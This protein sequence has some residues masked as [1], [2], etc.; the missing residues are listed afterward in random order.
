MTRAGVILGTAGVHESRAG[1]RAGGRQAHRHLGVRLRAVRDADRH[2]APFDGDDAHGHDRRDRRERA[3]LAGAARRERRRRP[4]RCCGVPEEDPQRAA[5]R[6]RRRTARARRRGGRSPDPAGGASKAPCALAASVAGSPHFCCWASPLFL[7]LR[8]APRR[9]PHPNLV[10]LQIVP[11]QNTSF[12]SPISATVGVPGSR[13]V[14]RRHPRWF[15]SRKP[16]KRHSPLRLRVV[17]VAESTAQLAG[18]DRRG[19][20]RSGRR[21]PLDRRSSPTES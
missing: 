14:P 11:P 4:T 21:Q 20:L 10:S 18:T 9:R 17:R 13:H 19:G 1:A 6:H 16:R 12:S 8:P 7:A 15:S 2:G 5:A 3:R